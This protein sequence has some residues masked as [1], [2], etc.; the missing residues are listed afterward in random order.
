MVVAFLILIFALGAAS[1]FV[2][3]RFFRFYIA[4]IGAGLGA[5]LGNQLGGDN[6][7]LTLIFSIG[8]AIALGLV[9]YFVYKAGVALL[10]FLMGF[11]VGSAVCLLCALPYLTWLPLVSGLVLAV[12]ACF[13]NR[14]FIVVGTAFSGAAQLCQAVYACTMLGT[15]HTIPDAQ[16]ALQAGGGNAIVSV[17]TL[18]LAIAGMIFQF[19]HLPKRR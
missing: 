2:G 12:V 18:V 1:C 19:R 3:Y 4:L 17:A 7:T 16:R 8:L 5:L 11:L 9:A 10:G 14:S 13:L 15:L 6:A